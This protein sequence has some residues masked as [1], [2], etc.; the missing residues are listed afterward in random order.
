MCAS[1]IFFCFVFSHTVEPT[2]TG[3]YVQMLFVM[4]LCN[5][6]KHLEKV[7]QILRRSGYILLPCSK[8]NETL[9]LQYSFTF[10]TGFIKI[11]GD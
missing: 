11:H 7:A 8:P 6:S 10:S 2:L 3:K 5:M 1:Q 4:M 9:L